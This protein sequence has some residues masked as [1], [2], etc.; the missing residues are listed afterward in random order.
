MS[1][2]IPLVFRVDYEIGLDAKDFSPAKLAEISAQTID[3]LL[4]LSV[5]FVATS[6]P[7][8]AA[9]ST[10][11]LHDVPARAGRDRDNRRSSDR[12]CLQPR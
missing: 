5:L 4:P 1:T 9:R 6:G 11:Q 3:L 2:T 8:R 10:L 12:C 7:Q